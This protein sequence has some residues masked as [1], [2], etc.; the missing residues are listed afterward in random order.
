MSY[1]SAVQLIDD[2]G[3]PFGLINN[4]GSPQ[5][6]S[7]PYLQALAEG[8]IEN[9]TEWTKI[10]YTPTM[11][12]AE[13]DLWSNAGSIN[14]PASAI[15]MEVIS[16]DGTGADVNTSIKTGTSTGGTATSLIDAGVN[17]NAATAVAVGDCVVL[18]KSGTTP[19][20]GFVTAVTSNTELAIAGGF[21]KGGTGYGTAGRAYAVSDYSSTAGAHAVNI[22][23]LDGSFVTKNEIV[24][25]NGNTAVATVNTDL[26]RINSFRMIVAG[27]NGKPTGNL[28]LR[29]TSDTP[30]Y[31]YITA[32][33]TRAR[34]SAYT[35]PAGK[36]L[37][38]V[39]FC[40]SY[41]YSTNQTHYAR[42]YTRATQNAGFR[43]PGIFYPF[44]EVVCANTSQL[45][46]L[47]IPT[48]ILQK[49][50]IKVSGIATF[51]G[52]ASVALRG[53]IE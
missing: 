23:Y 19:E 36:T 27:S 51:A 11:T 12:T 3:L 26:Y 37:Y 44:T 35:V 1:F 28:S 25:L 9:H 50:D 43:T 31:S 32:G 18:D 38:I 10:G 21:S 4:A 46:T 40:V 2:D 52:V 22:E 14:W 42:L 20:Y 48:K 53:W 33:F 45:V 8:D 13:S 24:L 30:I 29:H 6:C 47:D 7:Q 17:F 39:E 41:G 49:V 34:N 15:Q 5:I 16:S